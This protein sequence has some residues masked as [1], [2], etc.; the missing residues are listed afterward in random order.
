MTLPSSTLT[1]L[2]T[3]IEVNTKLAQ[4]HPDR[5]SDLLVQ[6]NEMS[7]PAVVAS[8]H[9]HH[10]RPSKSYYSVHQIS[11]GKSRSNY[12]QGL[13]LDRDSYWLR[14]HNIYSK[15]PSEL[16]KVG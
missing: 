12:R 10:H 3:D 16:L 2:F 15:K 5:V 14:L 9:D 13:F 4:E 1:F 6:R 7:N 11:F 8:P